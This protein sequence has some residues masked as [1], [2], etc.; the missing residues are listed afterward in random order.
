EDIVQSM[1][2]KIWE[3]RANLEIRQNIR[4]Y[5]FRA[6]YHQCMNHLDHRLVER[7][8]VDHELHDNL[9]SI[10]QPEVFPDELEENIKDAING[11]PGQCRLIFMMSRYEELRYAEIAQ[12]LNLSVNTIEN[13]ISKALKILR[14]KLKDNIV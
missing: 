12:K 4:S 6:V 8:H 11:L 5:L 13:Q 14:S 3:K 1:F 7:K 9:R 10:Q 2:L